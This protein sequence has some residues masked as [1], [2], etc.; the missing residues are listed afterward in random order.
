MWQ[1]TCAAKGYFASSKY[2][3]LP[4]S[5]KTQ[6][7]VCYSNKNILVQYESLLNSI[8]IS[9]KRGKRYQHWIDTGLY[10][11]PH[12]LLNDTHSP[13][14]SLII[15]NSL[16]ELENKYS[17]GNNSVYQS[18][19]KLLAM[20]RQYICRIVS[21][22]DENIEQFGE[23][24]Q[25]IKS[26]NYFLNML[27][28]SARTLEEALQRVL[29]WSSL[30]WQTGHRHVGLGRL[31]W[32]LNDAVFCKINDESFTVIS[33]FYDELH[34]FYEYKSAQI[35]GD[36][37]QII[38]LGGSRPDGSYFCNNLTYLFI[39]VLKNKLLPDPK[40]VLRTSAKMPEDLLE[41]SLRTIQTGIG[42]P[43]LANDDRIVP[44]LQDY[45]YKKDDAYN[46]ITSSCWE[47]L[48]FGKSWGKGNMEDVNFARAMVETY[49]SEAFTECR[50][51][52]EVLNIFVHMLQKETERAISNIDKIRW[53]KNPLMT[54][55]TEGCAESGKDMA[56]GGAVYHDYG[57]LA[58]GTANAVDSLM[59]IKKLVFEGKDFSLQQLKEAAQ[60]NF[61]GY[62]DIREALEEE[63]FFGTD[64]SETVWLVNY[65]MRCAADICK[66]YRSCY[67]GRVKIG[68][69]SPSYVTAGYACGATLDGRLK[70]CPLSVHISSGRG[71]PYTQIFNFA[72]ALDYSGFCHNGNVTDLIISPAFLEENFTKF[73]KIIKTG[74]AAGVFQIQINV[75]GSRQLIEASRHP[76]K[77]PNLIVRVWG[78]SAYFADL[79]KQYKEML[80]KR[81]MESE[82]TAK[83]YV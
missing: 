59:N 72:A 39:E 82:K 23:D 7:R 70:E 20:V 52:Q 53:E 75:T 22:I 21:R 8:R 10:R 13:D 24:A 30:F 27:N 11:Y 15:H 1:K 32:I 80:I 43:L 47:P 35:K 28:A 71:M 19:R 69:S 25:L 78:F 2:T 56:E 14:Y 73:K 26:R 3:C 38:I 46:Y 77:Y 79:P 62:G 81:T 66:K 4:E 42:C 16:A 51:F 83:Q 54:L 12:L 57:I 33:D 17:L 40:I 65:L 61:A 5:E 44:C 9:I 45:G 76:Q 67:G 36:T 64:S 18:D 29:F 48:I 34:R 55:F 37:G 74:L 41:L 68:F 60:L 31:D 50:N 49:S 63:R 6:K 58:V